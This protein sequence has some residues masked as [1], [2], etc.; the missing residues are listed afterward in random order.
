[1]ALSWKKRKLRMLRDTPETRR[2]P[3]GWSTKR[4]RRSPLR[5]VSASDR[6]RSCF[7]R[8]QIRC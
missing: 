5:T 8:V 7:K 6:T 1:M 2:E 4:R 3:P